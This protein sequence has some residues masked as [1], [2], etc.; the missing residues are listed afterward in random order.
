M[1]MSRNDTSCSVNQFAN[2]KRA[3][4]LEDS[5]HFLHSKSMKNTQFKQLIKH[6]MERLQNVTIPHDIGRFERMIQYY[7]GIMQYRGLQQKK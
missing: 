3:D 6:E 5:S 7:H 1:L 4:S 2:M